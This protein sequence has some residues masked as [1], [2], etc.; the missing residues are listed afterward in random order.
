MMKRS[1]ENLVRDVM[2]LRIE[3]RH[4]KGRFMLIW[5]QVVKADMAA[6]GINGT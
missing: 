1:E 5:E 4:D 2:E 6:C 3:G